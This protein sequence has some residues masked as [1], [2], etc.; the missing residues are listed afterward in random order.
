MNKFYFSPL[1]IE[2]SLYFLSYDECMRKKE[3]DKNYEV[4]NTTIYLSFCQL[5]LKM[6]LYLRQL[7]L[8]ILADIDA[9]G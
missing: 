1:T 5:L 4:D 2:R 9:G 7:C 3:I 6:R 8:Y